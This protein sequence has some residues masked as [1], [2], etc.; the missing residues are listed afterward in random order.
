VVRG[1][2]PEPRFT[3][4]VATK[5]VVEKDGTHRTFKPGTDSKW[6]DEPDE[7]N[8]PQPYWREKPKSEWFG[9]E[10]GDSDE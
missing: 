4:K 2:E 6:M 7:F 8:D 5:Y 3:R 1:P 10:E 9:F